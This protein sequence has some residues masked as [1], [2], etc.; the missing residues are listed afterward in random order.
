MRR[1]ALMAAA[2]AM[3]LFTLAPAAQAEVVYNA[4]DTHSFSG[5]TLCGGEDIL[6]E[7]TERTLITST[8]DQAGGS[9]VVFHTNYMKTEGVG[10]QSGDGY[11]IRQVSN[12]GVNAQPVDPAE[13]TNTLESTAVIRGSVIHLGEAGPQPDDISVLIRYHITQ[14]ANGVVTDVYVENIVCN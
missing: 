8:E 7:V 5:P 9:H 14:N 10:L 11:I 12:G 13:T 1:I 4:V 6:F 3:L 2:V